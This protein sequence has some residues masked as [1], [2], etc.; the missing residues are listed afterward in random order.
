MALEIKRDEDLPEQAERER[1]YLSHAELLT[2]AKAAD[3]FETL[4]L[5]RGYCGFRS[6]RQSHKDAGMWGIGC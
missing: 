6:G 5:V 2:L 3:R 4:T 1:R